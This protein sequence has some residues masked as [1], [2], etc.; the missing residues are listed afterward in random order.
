MFWQYP[1][2]RPL[3][4]ERAFFCSA[5]VDV[6]A[7]LF[8]DIAGYRARPKFYEPTTIPYQQDLHRSS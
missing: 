3:A 1:G 7:V 8:L 6:L 2:I 5:L 4:R